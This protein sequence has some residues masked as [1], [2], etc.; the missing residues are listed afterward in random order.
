M[1]RNDERHSYWAQDRSMCACCP[2]EVC[3]PMFG[4]HCAPAPESA[5][6]SRSLCATSVAAERCYC[7]ATDRYAAEFLFALWCK[8]LRKIKL[9]G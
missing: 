6:N 4:V 8:R 5:L 9:A 2:A 1:K 7:T 3:V